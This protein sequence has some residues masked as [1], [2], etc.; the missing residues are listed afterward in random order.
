MMYIYFQRRKSGA[1][2]FARVKLI[3]CATVMGACKYVIREDDWY[4]QTEPKPGSTCH[5]ANDGKEY[6]VFNNAQIIPVYVV[7][8]DIG[9]DIARHLAMQAEDINT[10]IRKTA[11]RSRTSWAKSATKTN[12]TLTPSDKQRVKQA[13]MAKAKK[14]FPYG[15]GTTT[16]T[17]FQGAGGWR[18]I[19]R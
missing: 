10:Y 16:G 5:V 6:V 1:S 2:A 13:L 18:G 17:S 3:A 8:L 14:H 12:E 15:Y 19:G 4:N 11:G 7:H 9:R